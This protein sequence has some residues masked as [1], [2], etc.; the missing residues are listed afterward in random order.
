MNVHTL[1]RIRTCTPSNGTAAELH[2]R[3]H[4]Q[5]DQQG[6]PTAW[7]VPLAAR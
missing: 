3:P 6:H 2:L 1:R 7:R 4:G 5:R